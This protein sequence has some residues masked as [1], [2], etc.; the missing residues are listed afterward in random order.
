MRSKPS[1]DKELMYIEGTLF[2]VDLMEGDYRV[3]KSKIDSEFQEKETPDNIESMEG[4]YLVSSA[5][6]LMPIGFADAPEKP[7]MPELP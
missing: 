1:F 6:N 7:V 2:E 4:G 5:T 3:L